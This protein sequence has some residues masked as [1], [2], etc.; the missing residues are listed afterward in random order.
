MDFNWDTAS[1]VVN[2]YGA[3]F[4]I[5]DDPDQVHVRI[6]DFVVGSIYQ[7]LVK[8]LVKAR[9][10]FDVPNISCQKWRRYL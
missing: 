1:V 2:G 10:N 6:A 4:A 7:D 5:N 9:N 3:V 8:N